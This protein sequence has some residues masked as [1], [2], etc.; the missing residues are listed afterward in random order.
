MFNLSQD[1][2]PADT[3]FSSGALTIKMARGHIRCLI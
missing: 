3:K 2:H 1:T